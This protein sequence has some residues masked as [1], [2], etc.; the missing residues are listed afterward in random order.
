MPNSVVPN[1]GEKLAIAE[2][3]SKQLKDQIKGVL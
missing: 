2:A 3:Q 1:S